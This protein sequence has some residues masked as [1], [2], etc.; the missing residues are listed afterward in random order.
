[1]CLDTLL[2]FSFVTLAILMWRAEDVDWV[3]ESVVVVVV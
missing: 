1:M 3:H 2:D